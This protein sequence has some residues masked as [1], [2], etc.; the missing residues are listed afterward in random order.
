MRVKDIKILWGR[1]GNRCAICKLEITPDGETETIGE[2][3]HIISRSAKGP[4]GN[5]PL[6][7]EKRDEYSNLIL[8]CPNHHSEIDKYSKKWPTAKLHEVKANHEKWVSDSLDK[9]IISY[10]PIDNSDFLKS[11]EGAWSTFASSRVWLICGLTPLR[12]EDDAINP[13]EDRII[14]AINSIR[15]P[16]SGLWDL[17]LNKY[18]TRPNENGII[19]L[20]VSNIENGYGHKISIFRNGHCE[21]L[22]CLEASIKQITDH[23]MYIDKDFKT[24]GSS[25]I[26]R[27]THVAEAMTNQIKTLKSLWERCLP[28]K[29]MTL[30]LEI[31]NTHETLLFSSE[32][33]YEGG[34]Y[35]F[36]VE[37]NNLNHTLIIEKDFDT[38]LVIASVL[39]RFANYFGMVLD[40]IYTPEGNF[41]RPEK[42]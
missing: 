41:S 27:Y 35:G 33:S 26:I 11:I 34:V 18:H 31:L 25:H 7:L 38:A 23:A 8:L 13:L 37:A 42:I 20:N 24:I 1:S 14:E 2:I 5:S 36:P 22:L 30:T 39:K 32:K 40:Q 6:S 29:N 10:Q 9:G 21:Y 3:A 16:N 19:N 28:F 17:H 15:L 4:R 12:I